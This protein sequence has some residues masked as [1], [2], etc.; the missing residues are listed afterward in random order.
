ME[1]D[2]EV[3]E[4]GRVNKGRAG[5]KNVTAKQRGAAVKRKQMEPVVESENEN[6]HQQQKKRRS[7]IGRGK[8]R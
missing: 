4:E 7:T 3:L 5:K 8:A 6:Q 2:L 1:E